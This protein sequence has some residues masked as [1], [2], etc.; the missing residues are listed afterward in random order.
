MNNGSLF[1][2]SELNPQIALN[3]D[4]A[5]SAAHTVISVTASENHHA[6]P[7]YSSARLTLI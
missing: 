4:F 7:S 3:E 2:G 6:R 5:D 1:A